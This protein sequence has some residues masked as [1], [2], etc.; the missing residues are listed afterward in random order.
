MIGSF[1]FSI[2]LCLLGAVCVEEGLNLVI[3]L[4]FCGRQ[5][6]AHIFDKMKSGVTHL[7]GYPVEVVDLEKLSK[8]CSCSCHKVC[9]FMVQ[10][11][12]CV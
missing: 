5:S 8:G 4:L 12:D 1:G 9:R 2:G 6:F 11:G 7:N 10:V 3:L